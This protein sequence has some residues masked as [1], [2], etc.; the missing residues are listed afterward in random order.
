MM[1]EFSNPLLATCPGQAVAS[2][3]AVLSHGDQSQVLTMRW[4]E[5]RRDY[6]WM[7][8]IVLRLNRAPGP[9]LIVNEWTTKQEVRGQSRAKGMAAYE[10]NWCNRAQ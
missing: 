8:T 10:S 1:V 3:V 4:S 9:N 6:K 5:V 2:R 7:G